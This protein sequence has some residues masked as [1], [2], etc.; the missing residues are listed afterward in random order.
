MSRTLVLGHAC[1]GLLCCSLFAAARA[2]PPRLLKVTPELGG[3]VD[4]ATRELRFEFDQDMAV[5]GYSICGGGPALPTIRPKS[6]PRGPRWDGP[7]V[8]VLPV[9]LEP[10]HDY[11]FSLNCRSAQNFRSA[12]GEQL[13]PTPIK[14]R[15]AAADPGRPPPEF[16]PV[17]ALAILREAVEK[18]YAHI[19]LHPVDWKARFDEFGPRLKAAKE[20]RDF[21]RL[22]G[23]LLSATGDLHAW[24]EAGGER[25]AAGQRRVDPNANPRLMKRIVP[26]WKAVTKNIA[27]GRFDDGVG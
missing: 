27:R 10:G 4:P 9:R 17:E 21:A 22:A 18:S 11:E 1:A 15:A 5:S 26:G 20:P 16:D 2:Q 14:F 19:E 7:R 24:V 12:T 25:F 8:F 23:E 13:A 3:A 6:G